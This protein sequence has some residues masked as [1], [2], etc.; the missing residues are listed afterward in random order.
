MDSLP[1]RCQATAHQGEA[2]GVLSCS[3]QG[4]DLQFQLHDPILG[5]KRPQVHNISLAPETLGE[6]RFA[7]RWYGGAPRIELLVKELALIAQLPRAEDGRLLLL[8]SWR[9]RRRGRAAVEQMQL[10]LAD[11]R[12]ARLQAEIDHLAGQ[13]P[14]QR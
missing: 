5:V 12:F 14:R 11:Q 4:V 2:E 13:N 9:D 7:S 8:L 3:P 1:F 10:Y 6:I